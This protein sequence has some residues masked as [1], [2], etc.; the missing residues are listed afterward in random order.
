MN[1]MDELRPHGVHCNATARVHHPLFLKPTRA[2][3]EATQTSDIN[4]RQIWV[5]C[6]FYKKWWPN[7]IWNSNIAYSEHQKEL[8]TKDK[9]L[10]IIKHIF[11]H[12]G[13]CPQMNWM[14]ELRPHGVHCNATVRVHHPLFLKPTRAYNEAT[15][16]ADVNI[17]QITQ[18]IDVVGTKMS[19]PPLI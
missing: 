1:W 16:T 3:N 7:R 2:Y 9:I 4:I 12:L 14:D 6:D 5:I 10:T 19:L 18:I 17:R 8:C 13:Q 11:Y 15:Q